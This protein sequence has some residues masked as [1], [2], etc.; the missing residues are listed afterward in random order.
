MQKTSIKIFCLS[1]EKYRWGTLRCFRNV[2]VSKNFKHKKDITIFG[3]D[4]FVSQC[5]K[6]S[7]GTPS[8]FRKSSSKEKKLWIRGVGLNTN[9]GHN[10]LSHSTEKIRRGT[11]LCFRNVLYQNFFG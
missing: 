10:F 3:W 2:R 7:Y 11:L 4:F 1:T 8:V 5:R 6:N 9:F